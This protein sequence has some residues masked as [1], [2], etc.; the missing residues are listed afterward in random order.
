MGKTLA[1]LFAR[2]G[3]DVLIA[4]SRGPESF[5]DIAAELGPRVTPVAVDVVFKKLASAP[6]EPLAI[7]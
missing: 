6:A 4:N 2:Q 3:V 5:A 1:G 7:N